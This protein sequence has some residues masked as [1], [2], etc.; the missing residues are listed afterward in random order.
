MY[1]L[2]IKP[3]L[4]AQLNE[5]VSWQELELYPLFDYQL[6]FELRVD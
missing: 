1:I 3:S 4:T 5:N 2:V 6:K